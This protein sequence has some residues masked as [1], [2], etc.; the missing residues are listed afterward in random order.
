[1]ARRLDIT[2]AEQFFELKVPVSM[3]MGSIETRYERRQS[4]RR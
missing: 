3:Y 4:D 1:L 2:N